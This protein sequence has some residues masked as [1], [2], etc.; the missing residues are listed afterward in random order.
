M[1]METRRVFELPPLPFEKAALEPHM[2][3]H[4]LSFHY[5]KHHAGYVKK[6]NKAL[7]GDKRLDWSLE[8]V[9]LDAAMNDAIGVFRN[10]AQIW[11]HTFFWNSLSADGCG[12]APGKLGEMITRDFGSMDGLR[13]AFVEVAAGE[14][15]S[16]WAWLVV[17][18]V[19]LRTMS[20]SDADT[21]I[22]SGLQPL[23][24]CDVWEHA[25]YLDYQNDRGAFVS[26]FLDQLVNWDFASAN[27][28][29][30]G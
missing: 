19:R 24:C 29:N 21:P 16:G 27:L 17:D 12:D 23:L 4:T 5:D 1:I 9:I 10:A 25:Y 20:T 8:K 30:Q 18:D 6:L 26:A 13:Q 3:A 7:E 11:N 2:S 15:G 22:V 14:F 28:E